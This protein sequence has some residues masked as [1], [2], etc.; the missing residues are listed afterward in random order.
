[1]NY[2]E[3]LL[4][5]QDDGIAV[6][7]AREGAYGPSEV[8]HVTWRDL[9]RRVGAIAASLRAVGVTPGDRV[10]GERASLSIRN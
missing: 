2:A 1:M 6:T 3:N 5:R 10:A 7:S 8:E 9:R 4:A